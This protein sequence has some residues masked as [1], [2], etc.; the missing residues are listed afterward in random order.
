MTIRNHRIPV[1]PRWADPVFWYER[2]V[3]LV[4]AKIMN[5]L[6]GLSL[7]TAQNQEV[8]AFF[9]NRL[10]HEWPQG[11]FAALEKALEGAQE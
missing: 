6:N 1:K 9:W 7:S 5:R 3:T 2:R 11:T 4:T 10:M 8:R